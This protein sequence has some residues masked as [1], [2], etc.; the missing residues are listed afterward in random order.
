MHTRASYRCTMCAHAVPLD[1][2]V[3]PEA[4]NYLVHFCGLDCF[5]RWKTAAYL[6]EPELSRSMTLPPILK[7]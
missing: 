6:C 5:A 4:M 7:L 2:V 1:E 3:V